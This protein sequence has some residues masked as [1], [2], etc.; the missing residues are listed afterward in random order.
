MITWRCIALP[1]L[2]EASVSKDTWTN[3]RIYLS[4]IVYVHTHIHAP[5]HLHMKACTFTNPY[6]S[7]IQTIPRPHRR[8][9]PSP[10]LPALLQRHHPSPFN[11]PLTPI[12][13]GQHQDEPSASTPQASSKSP[14]C[15]QTYLLH[16]PP[17]FSC[18]SPHPLAHRRISV[19]TG[20]AG[21]RI[22]RRQASL[23][24]LPTRPHPFPPSSLDCNAR[25]TPQFCVGGK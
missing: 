14:R 19:S 1:G 22:G 20:S 25:S 6:P 7:T 5:T 23:S 4:I 8:H 16:L 15:P 11:L 18:I 13:Q 12:P 3:I 9:L 10:S 17:V 2:S 21:H 24:I